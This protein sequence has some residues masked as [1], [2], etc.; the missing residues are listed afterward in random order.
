MQADKYYGDIARRYDQERCHTMRWAKEQ[1][2]VFDMIYG[3]SVLDVPI[4]TGRYVEI[5]RRRGAGSIVGV[6][7]S[8][9]MLAQATLKYP[10]LNVMRGSIFKLP[11]P[12]KSFD[13]VVC[14]RLLDWLTPDDMARAIK[15]LRRVARTLIVSIRHGK[16]EIRINQTH[17]LA[18]FY[19]V[20]NG[21]HICMRRTTEVTRDGKEEIFRLREPWWSDVLAQ[22]AYHGHTPAFELERLARFWL[23]DTFRVQESDVRIS[24]EYWTGDVLGEIIDEMGARYDDGLPDEM[25][26]VTSQPPRFAAGPATILRA[27]GTSIVLDGRRRINQ[28]RTTPGRYPVLVLTHRDHRPRKVARG[29]KVGAAD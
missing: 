29:K 25:R 23:G 7:I 13:N 22:F 27:R 19:E 21:L 9:D 16:E 18:T 1:I 14:T 3:G 11:F 2:A 6:D 20:I 17:D 5:Y 28:W 8:D 4:G 26:Y 15:E 12:D 24:A 10:G